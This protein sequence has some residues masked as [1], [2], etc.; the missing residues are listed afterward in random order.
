MCLYGAGAAIA[1]LL[2]ARQ[3]E[4]GLHIDVSQRE[5]TSLAVGEQI[6]AAS[7]FGAADCGDEVFPGNSDI[8]AKL[9][10]VFAV[11]DGWLCVTA[12]DHEQIAGLARFLGCDQAAV[13]QALSEW[14]AQRSARQATDALRALKLAVFKANTGAEAAEQPLIKSGSAFSTTQQGAMV[15]G[16]PFQFDVSPMRIYEESP[17]MGEH[18]DRVIEILGD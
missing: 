8:N 6:A 16:F 18:T 9:Q 15:K 11:T 2:K 7:R 3:Q 17:G 4:A 14:L 5:V 1:A 13:A 12:Q 10:D